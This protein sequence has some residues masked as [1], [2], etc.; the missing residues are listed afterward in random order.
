M[1]LT[2]TRSHAGQRGTRPAGQR[3]PRSRW[4]V[5]ALPAITV[6]IGLYVV[7]LIL[8]GILGFTNWS[9]FSSDI[10][11]TGTDN[12]VTLVEQ[13]SLANQVRL[14]VIYAIT[15]S[16]ISNGMS[17]PLAL[18]LE[19]RSRSSVFFRAV[20]FIPVL[21]SPIAAGYVWAGIMGPNGPF[22]QVASLAGADPASSLLA[23]PQLAIFV[24][25]AVDGWKWSGF[26]TL[27]YIA[28]LATVPLELKEAARTDGAKAWAIFR[29]VKLPFLAP[30][31]TYNITVTLI[32]A[33]SAFD[34]IVAMT[35]GGPGSSTRVLNILTV[36]QFGA[37]YFGLASMTSMVV[38]VLVVS[39]AIPL[40]WWL[41]RREMDA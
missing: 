12:F 26:F 31:F 5:F 24:V 41:R 20:F 9:A 11:F 33:M 13:N 35:G 19:R 17:L 10:G 16:V 40:V 32:G 39:C 37:G 1:S 30:A 18:A 34:I 22:Q 2:P 21:L 27:I 14:T 6:V 28:A 23:D 25:G 29:H 3:R 15:A 4:W 36:N 38:T 7:P 8:N